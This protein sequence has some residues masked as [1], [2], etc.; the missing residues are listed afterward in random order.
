[1]RAKNGVE[2]EGKRASMKLRKRLVALLILS[3][4]FVL[5][6][7]TWFIL[8]HYR[9]E[10]YNSSIEGPS[11]QTSPYWTIIRVQDILKWPIF[12]T[13]VCVAVVLLFELAHLLALTISGRLS[14]SKR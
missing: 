1:M 11:P 7:G 5:F 2:Q 13:A 10:Y 14:N 12:V 4:A 8:N 9:V 3:S 6:S